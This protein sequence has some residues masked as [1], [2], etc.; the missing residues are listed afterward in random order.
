M[1]RT[2]FI[3]L[4]MVATTAPA[5]LKPHI[6]VLV[7]SWVSYMN[8][9]RLAWG[10]F[11]NEIPLLDVVAGTTILSML[12]AREKWRLSWS[13]LLF[14][15]ILLTFWI[16]LTSTLNQGLYE[17]WPRFNRFY[18][19]MLFT[20]ITAV[21]INT[22]IRL[23]SFIYVMLLALGFFAAKGGFF[24]LLTG[25]GHI[26]VGP[27]KSMIADR[28]H[29]GVALIMCIP[30]CFYAYGHGRHKL[31]K[32]AGL[33]GLA[34]FTTAALGT[35]SRGALLTLA[36][37]VG[38]MI[39]RSKQRI[40][41]MALV[42][43][44]AL[45]A[46]AF[47]PDTWTERML[48]I[49]EYEKDG[50]ATSRILSWAY[51]WRIALDFPLTGSGF[52]AFSDPYFAIPYISEGAKLRA[53]HSIYYEVLAEHGFIGLFFFFLLMSTALLT[54]QKIL[55]MV[56]PYAELK[57]AKDLAVAIQGGI[58]GY[59]VGGAFLAMSLFDLYYHFIVLMIA[60]YEIAYRKVKELQTRDHGEVLQQN[61]AT[62]FTRYPL[63]PRA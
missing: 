14:A 28:N 37:V 31:I 45:L 40:P 48:T 25:G 51:A 19:V 55:K 61:P 52:G 16:L 47:L 17:F 12:V 10:E 44:A 20:F 30:L 36:A 53:S 11:I 63:R 8:P 59:A 15:L 62:V 33:A 2:I 13:P 27:P 3:L 9:H 4:L 54:G 38:F 18:K 49:T 60:T 39:M 5:L 46:F 50:S 1:L 24:T 32:W 23:D 57:W 34:L 56:K 7:W 22:R 41:L 6:G 26:V 43:I 29:L 21:L 58:I 35:Q 42:S